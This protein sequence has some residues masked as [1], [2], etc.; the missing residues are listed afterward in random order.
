MRANAYVEQ[1]GRL[2]S[3]GLHREALDFAARVEPSVDP[4]LGLDEID[5]VTSLLEQ[6]AMVVDMEGAGIEQ[7]VSPV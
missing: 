1:I 5:Q 7:A 2:V 6:A 4:P 3:E